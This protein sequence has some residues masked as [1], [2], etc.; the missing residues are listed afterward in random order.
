MKVKELIAELQKY[1][2]ELEVYYYSD[3]DQF[4]IKYVK[5]TQEKIF[6]NL[7]R[8]KGFAEKPIIEFQSFDLMKYKLKDEAKQISL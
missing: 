4:L 2:G 5:L 8:P 6:D 3:G 1:D 7:G